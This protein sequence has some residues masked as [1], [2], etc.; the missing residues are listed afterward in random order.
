MKTLEEIVETGD[1]H[2]YLRSGLNRNVQTEGAPEDDPDYA[3]VEE[4][5]ERLREAVL[6]LMDAHQLDALV[7]PTFNYPPRFIGDLNSPYGA[8][9][10]TLSPPTGFPAFNV[11]MG[12]SPGG[13]PAGLQLL[14]RPFGEPTLIRISFAY[15]QA[16]QH[17]R[18]PALTPPLR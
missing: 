11:P 18:P 7:Y 12:Y 13:L 9:S 17:R 16:T 4:E 6:A 10:G 5:S 15:E 3:T 2:P 1:F 8:N 14:G